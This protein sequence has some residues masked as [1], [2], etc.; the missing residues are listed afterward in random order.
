[1]NGERF[2]LGEDGPYICGA[3][4]S[5]LELGANTEQLGEI[6]D[7]LHLTENRLAR[8]QG[9]ACRFHSTLTL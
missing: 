3:L 6:G 1:L 5:E 2:G 8:R 4:A 7:R 9:F